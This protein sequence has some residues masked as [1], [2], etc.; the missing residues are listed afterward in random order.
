MSSNKNV[1][2]AVG[3][4]TARACDSCIKKRARWYCAADD[5]FLCQACDASVHSANP[6]ARRHERVR[7]KTASNKSSGSES[8]SDNT[9]VPS[10]HRGFTRK[11][12][13]PRKTG[14]PIRNVT[15]PLV[16]EV[17][18]DELSHEENEEDQLLYNC[19]VPTYDPFVAELCTSTANSNEAAEN[20]N[21][22]A[23]TDAHDDESTADDAVNG[24]ESKPVRACYNGDVDSLHGFL[25]SDM[26]LAEFAADVE[27]MLG[28]GLVNESFAMEELGLVDF[29]EKDFTVKV[30]Q[31]EGAVEAEGA[32]D[33]EECKVFDNNNNYNNHDQIDLEREP[34]E[35]N[36]DYDSPATCGDEDEKIVK[37]EMETSGEGCHEDDHEAK[38]N[39]K[40]KRKILL[41]LDYES[42]I[43]AWASQG[44][45]W[46]TGD[47]PNF[48]PEECW[49]DCM[50]GCPYTHSIKSYRIYIFVH[51]T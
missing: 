1:A 15:L 28:R 12:R 41:S 30:E 13:T 5:A 45:P 7:L 43:N 47:R 31:Q 46:T 39:N 14:K 8:L 35:L 33:I 38:K 23:K 29:R 26:D 6:L 44:S 51:V 36:F 24:S 21:A 50:V 27:S 3:G 19:R 20:N 37:E 9:H 4:K 16:P 49:P 42:V 32:R 11:A 25:P 40:K 34:F 22:T 10:W 17:G 18:A 2:N 48:D